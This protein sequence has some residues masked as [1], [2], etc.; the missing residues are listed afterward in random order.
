M[1]LFTGASLSA[2][3]KSIY[4]LLTLDENQ[5]L[6]F[7][8]DSLFYFI[9]IHTFIHIN[10]QCACFSNHS[11]LR[12]KTIKFSYH[13]SKF[14]TFESMTHISQ[15]AKTSVVYSAKKETELN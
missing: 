5:V 14:Q 6:T 13:C 4:Y 7:Q 8:L 1:N 3:A 2:L 11:L 12:C 15:T 10:V 9:L